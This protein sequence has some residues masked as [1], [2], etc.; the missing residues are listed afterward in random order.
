MHDSCKRQYKVNQLSCYQTRH[1]APDFSLMSVQVLA[2]HIVQGTLVNT[3]DI[4]LSSTHPHSL[5]L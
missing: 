5:G 4:A 1:V 2:A 3:K